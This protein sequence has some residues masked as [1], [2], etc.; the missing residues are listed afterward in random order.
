MNAYERMIWQRR[1]FDA[2]RRRENNRDTGTAWHEAGHVVCGYLLRLNPTGATIVGG[3]GYSGMAYFDEDPDEMTDHELA[4]ARAVC[5]V[6]GL[7]AQLLFGALDHDGSE[8]DAGKAEF[9]LRAICRS[10]DEIDAIVES[11]SRTAREMLNMN[12]ATLCEVA[13]ALIN[14]RSLDRDRIEEIIAEAADADRDADDDDDDDERGDDGEELMTTGRIYGTSPRRSGEEAGGAFDLCSRSKR[15]QWRASPARALR[16]TIPAVA[17]PPVT[18]SGSFFSL[19][20]V[21]LGGADAILS[22]RRRFGR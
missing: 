1:Q 3:D 17:R 15:L 6:A 4:Y 2:D 21:L 12:F 18:R 9:A 16:M 11:A 7:E 5:C 19:V 22:H 20:G 14:E 13:L 10:E 8:Q